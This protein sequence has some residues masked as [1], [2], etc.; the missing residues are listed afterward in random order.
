MRT[1]VLAVSGATRNATPADWC[2]N[3]AQRSAT[4]RGSTI[5]SGGFTSGCTNWRRSIRVRAT[6]A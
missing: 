1:L 3:P 5:K 2:R 4:K 6:G